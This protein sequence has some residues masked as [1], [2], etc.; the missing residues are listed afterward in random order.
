MVLVHSA[1]PPVVTIAKLKEEYYQVCLSSAQTDDPPN[2]NL[3]HARKKQASAR[4]FPGT[5][6]L[7]FIGCVARIGSILISRW[8]IMR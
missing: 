6:T 2:T 7:H 8:D 3:D 5:L 1:T 4:P